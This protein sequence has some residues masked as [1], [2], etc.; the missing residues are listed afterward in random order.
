VKEISRFLQDECG[1]ELMEH[2]VLWAFIVVV[3]AIIVNGMSSVNMAWGIAN[4][5]LSNAA[6]STS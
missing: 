3:I 4:T 5:Q 1:Q 6:V 2:A